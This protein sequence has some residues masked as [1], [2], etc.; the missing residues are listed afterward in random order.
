[1]NLS[2]DKNGYPTGEDGTVWATYDLRQAET[3]RNALIAQHIDCTLKEGNLRRKILYLLHVG[4]GKELDDAMNFVWRDSGGL[5]LQP[6]WHYSI[7]SENESF[8]KW[9]NG[10]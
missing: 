4:G 1:M 8:D 10:L 9:I 6:D 5:R 7:G 3:I 2:L